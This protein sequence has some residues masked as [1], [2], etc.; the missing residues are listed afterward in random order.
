[1][2]LPRLTPRGLSCSS[3]V[4]GVEASEFSV[5]T[6]EFT[7]EE[8]EALHSALEA[9]AIDPPIVPDLEAYLSAEGKIDSAYE[10]TQ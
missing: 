1:M 10:G 6:I 8:I 7:A 4:V 5:I 3:P 9:F 2:Y